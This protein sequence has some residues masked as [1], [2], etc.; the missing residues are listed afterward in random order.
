MTTIKH[1]VAVDAVTKLA[2]K[3]NV[4]L[5][6]AAETALEAGLDHGS[7]SKSKSETQADLASSSWQAAPWRRWGASSTMR[8]LMLAGKP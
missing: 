6:V 8:S 1:P 5:D 7:G 4:S 3:L 2:K